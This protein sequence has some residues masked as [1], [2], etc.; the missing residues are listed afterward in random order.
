MRVF[1]YEYFSELNLKGEVLDFGGG[2]A[3]KYQFL[4]ELWQQSC[5]IR[6]VNISANDMPD[7]LLA[8]ELNFYQLRTA[9]SMPMYPST[10]LNTFI[11]FKSGWAS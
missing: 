6:T 5:S 2:E 9:A 8:K 10:L 1:Q 7:F 3:A 11:A 4:Y